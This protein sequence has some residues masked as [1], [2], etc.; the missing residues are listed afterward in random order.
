[1]TYRGRVAFLTG[2]TLTD[3]LY[4]VVFP[5]LVLAAAFTLWRLRRGLFPLFIV[6]LVLTAAYIP[7]TALI[8]TDYEDADGW[9]DCWPS[10]SDL[11][12]GVGLAFWLGGGL[13]ALLGAISILGCLLAVVVDGR[14]RRRARHAS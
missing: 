14:R 9:I 13:L 11:Q 6:T 4:V 12:Q 1:M 8:A 10:C 2:E 3:A 5:S 7:A